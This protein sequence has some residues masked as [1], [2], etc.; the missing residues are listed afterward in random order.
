[1]LFLSYA[2]A[3]AQ[4]TVC[5]LSPR[6]KRT[7]TKYVSHCSVCLSH[8]GSFHLHCTRLPLSGR[9]VFKRT[10]RLTVEDLD[11]DGLL[12]LDGLCVWEAGIADVVVPGILSEYIREVEVSVQGLGHPAALRQPL[13]V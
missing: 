1:M 4:C 13:K 6:A 8:A 7:H 9:L 10:G 11:G 5:D 12:L 3:L 2:D